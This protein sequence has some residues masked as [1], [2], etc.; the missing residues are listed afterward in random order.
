MKKNLLLLTT[1]LLSFLSSAQEK[2]PFIDYTSIYEKVGEASEKGEYEKTIEHLNKISKNDSTYCSVMVTKSYYLMLL[3]KYDDAIAQAN[4]GL[5][6]ECYDLHSS[7]YINKVASFLRDDKSEEALNVCEEGLKRFPQ[8]KT[9]WYNKGVSLEGIGKIEEA[10]S[11]YQKTILLD[12]FNRKSYLQLGNICYKQELI[13]QALMCYNMYLLLEPDADNAFNTLKSLNNIVQSK[14]ENL[15]NPDIRIS[16][17]DESFEEIDLIINNRIALNEKYDAGNEI[18]IALTN[19]NHALLESLK[20]FSGN[21]GFWDTKF[22]PYY[23]WV[24][25]Q[26][27]FDVFIYTLSYSIENETYKKVVEKK[28]DEIQEFFDLSKEKWVEIVTNSTVLKNGKKEILNYYFKDGY[29]KGIGKKENNVIVGPWDLFNDK[30]RLTAKGTFNANG[31]RNG[32]WKFYNEQGK[33]R[34]SAEYLDGE[35]NGQNIIYYDN[36]KQQIVTV[37][38]DGNLEG[39]YLSF[40]KN[41]IL[42]QKKHFKNG[43]LDGPFKS[44]HKVGEELIESQAQYINGDVLEKYKKYFPTGKL[45][46]EI[47]FKNGKAEGRETKYYLNGELDTDLNS[48][49]GFV[50][51]YYKSFYSNGSPK[52][53]GQTSAGNYVGHW[54]TF[55]SN[56]NL[57]SDFNYDDKGQTDGEYKFYDIDGKLHYIF[58]YRKGEFIA[59]KYF[60]KEGSMIEE[61]RKKGGEF[62][63]KGYSPYGKIK[64]EGLYDIKGGKKGNWKYY[65]NYGILTDESA[66]VDNKLQGEYK[67]YY[68]SGELLSISQYK[69]DTIKG[70]Y[71]NYHRNGKMKIQGWYKDNNVHGEWRSYTPDGI[72]NE[73]NFYHKGLL[74]GEQLL[75]SGKGVKT[76][77]SIYKYGDPVKDIYYHPNGDVSFII[78]HENDKEKYELIYQHH[79]KNPSTKLTYV[80]G[81]KHGPYSFFD[82]YERKVADG[83]YLNGELHGELVWYHDNGNV[84]IKANYVNG[85]LDG[86]Y[87]FYHE[88][89]SLESKYNYRLGELQEEGINYHP[90]GN[91]E[92]KVKYHDDKRHGKREDYSPS[93]NLQLIRFYEYGRLI[94]YSYLDKNSK[95][96]PMIPIDNESGK[97]TTYY[98]N[99]NVSREMEY[100][101]G[102]LINGF[103]EYHYS[104]KLLEETTYI[105]GDFNGKRIEYFENGNIKKERHY[106][107]GNLSGVVKEYFQNGNLKKE[108]T[109]LHDVKEGITKTYDIDGKLIIEETYFNGDIISSTSK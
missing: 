40:S 79:N 67:E 63:Y 5:N 12:P 53:L 81:V 96:I 43:K 60:D 31:K 80:N 62:Y 70:Y 104:G 87:A 7:F 90:N 84:E 32:V 61:N 3:K 75:Y 85:E 20:N 23:L 6:T 8:N 86:D 33:I 77:L 52:E 83:K 109:Y 57:E 2:I 30:G 10:V 105:H 58:E 35:L 101:N 91:I 41:G 102:N 29:T 27:L 54:Q 65:S 44:F 48:K 59:Y 88:D 15:K 78:D 100:K 24:V 93:G 26:G 42:Q 72:V 47:T 51:G 108:E 99:G 56:G 82:F 107:L 13:S 74:H 37:Y 34:E 69:N 19:Q 66:Y 45:S 64:S 106:E 39:E 17:D 49:N 9:L 68:S 73:I 4:E 28:M 18:N 97:I 50:D 16:E 92:S 25:N 46:S 98:D 14:N 95:E 76:Q 11:A 22:V 55:Y 38:K 103:K 89:G 94:G 36:G 1:V 21:G 71:V